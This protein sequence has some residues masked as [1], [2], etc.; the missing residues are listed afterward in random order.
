M[1]MNFAYQFP[2]STQPVTKLQRYSTS[3]V[4]WRLGTYVALGMYVARLARVLLHLGQI[5]PAFPSTTEMKKKLWVERLKVRNQE[6]DA[7]AQQ[8]HS[9]Q[10]DEIW[11]KKSTRR[12]NN[13]QPTSA[14]FSVS[15]S[16]C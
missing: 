1:Q 16:L 9:I 7:I 5:V 15:L 6:F 13:L 14:L 12:L 3:R 8:Q 11:Y 10:P 4:S 2:I